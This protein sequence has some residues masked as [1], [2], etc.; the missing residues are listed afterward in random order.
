MFVWILGLVLRLNTETDN[1]AINL[2][3]YNQVVEINIV[4]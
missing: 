2:S 1:A 3:I 4:F